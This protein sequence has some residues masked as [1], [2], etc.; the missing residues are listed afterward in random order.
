MIGGVALPAG[1]FLHVVIASANRDHRQFADPDVFDVG[2]D[3]NRHI[4]FGH[5]AHFCAGNGV[6]RMEA[7]VAFGRL[8]ERFPD[9]RRAGP[10]ERPNR[11]RFRIIEKLPV[12]MGA[13]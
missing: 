3:P 13:N 1:T 6:A 2:R 11:S 10:T 12:T 8:L 4:A 7:T 5:G 9:F